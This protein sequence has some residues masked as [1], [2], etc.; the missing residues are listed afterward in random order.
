MRNRI[1]SLFV[2]GWIGS[3]FAQMS[4]PMVPGNGLGSFPVLGRGSEEPVLADSKRLQM[5]QSV[6]FSAASGGGSSMTQSLYRNEITYRL[7]DPLTLQ[8]DLAMMTPMTASGPAAQGVQTGAAYL[9]PSV[10]LEYR[11]SES[12]V[13]SVNYTSFT[14]APLG[15]PGSLP[16]H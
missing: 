11:P 4:G 16:W 1:V 8:L 12:M 3:A 9:L 15:S 10:G 14:N 2:I 7:S 6:T 5:H 13:F